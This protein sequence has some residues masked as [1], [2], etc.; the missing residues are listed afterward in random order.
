MEFKG[1]A[2]YALNNWDRATIERQAREITELHYEAG[3]M[4]AKLREE[5]REARC[6]ISDLERDHDML[7][8]QLRRSNH[9]E[10]S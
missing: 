9:G 7:A 3:K 8:E 5:L 6:R 2:Y 1:N 4:E 10:G